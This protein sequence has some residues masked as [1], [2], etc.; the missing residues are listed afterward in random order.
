MRF[1]N[2]TPTDVPEIRGL[3]PQPEYRTMVGSWPEERHQKTLSEPDAVYIVAE[4][5]QGRIAAF[6]IL[7]G[8]QSEHKSVELKRIVVRIA[9]QGIGRKLLNEV[10]ERA[11]GE[12]GAHRLWLDVFVTN[13]RARHVYQSFGF[14][15]E[16]IRNGP[17]NIGG[18]A[19][20]SRIS[21]ARS[22]HSRRASVSED[23]ITQC[24]NQEI[25]HRGLPNVRQSRRSMPSRGLVQLPV[26][27]HTAEARGGIREKRRYRT[28]LRVKSRSYSTLLPGTSWSYGCIHSSASQRIMVSAY[29]QETIG[30]QTHLYL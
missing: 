6:A 30:L 15:E 26:H 13:D 21:V 14:R 16:G 27:L 23:V 10:A 12:Y 1:R 11:F 18:S 28:R 5:E 22:T 2:A 29:G 20:C 8:P 3:E 25:S 19:D 7:Q 9:N 17:G 4:D 24:F